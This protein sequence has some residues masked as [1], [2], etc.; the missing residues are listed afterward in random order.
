MKIVLVNATALVE[1]G[2]LTI[3]KQLIDNINNT[4]FRYYIFS[5][6]LSLKEE[7]KNKENVIFIF[8]NAKGLI[9][10]VIWDNYGIMRW[11][12]KNNINVDLFIS[13]Q[14]TGVNINK[15]IP[16]IVYIH[17]S[18]PFTDKSW[19]PF[20]KNE[21][22]LWFYKNI[23]S[24]FIGQHLKN[25]N[26]IIVQS[27][28]LK[29]KFSKKYNYI[30]NNIYVCKPN[31][32]K[33]LI[34]NIKQNKNFINI[35]KKNYNIF[36]PA[37]PFL[38]KNHMEIVNALNHLKS[39]NK[40]MSNIKIF[41]TYFKEENM[42]IY[43]KILEYNLKDN[44]TFLGNLT[45]LEMVYMYRNTDLVI[46]PS[47]IETFG[48]PLIEASSFGIPILC[49]DEEYSREVIGKYSGVKF[50]GIN[51]PKLWADA[52]YLN[53]KEKK[54]YAEFEYKN[55]NSWNSFFEI[56]NETIKEKENVQK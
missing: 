56:I 54:I 55:E 33:Y 11:I 15:N 23:Y 31:Y 26:K 12:K 9:N 8:P 36:Y 53:Y 21:R 13:L 42:D 2:G 1:G 45:F 39:Q 25:T 51:N 48:L 22:S 4:N 7:Y 49:A 24:F 14:N 17:Q 16:Q 37:T 35:D 41:F 28:W 43:S 32:N 34:N 50:I 5:S 38:Y 44:F 20:K 3:L 27:E 40:N 52:I 19:N 30:L 10:R 46:F 6:L 47:Y 29:D 18:I